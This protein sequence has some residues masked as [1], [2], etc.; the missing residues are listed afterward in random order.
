[1]TTILFIH[2]LFFI[3]VYEVSGMVPD[4]RTALVNKNSFPH[5]LVGQIGPTFF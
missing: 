5:G 2:S 3:D 1:M 4:P